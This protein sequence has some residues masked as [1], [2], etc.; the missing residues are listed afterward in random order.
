MRIGS[1]KRGVH[2]HVSNRPSDHVSAITISLRVDLRI[3]P[4]SPHT[5]GAPHQPRESTAALSVIAGQFPDRRPLDTRWTQPLRRTCSVRGN[6]LDV[7]PTLPYTS[8]GIWSCARKGMGVQLPPRAPR[9]C[10]SYLTLGEA[11]AAV[12]FRRTHWCSRSAHGH[13]SKPRP[14][15]LGDTVRRKSVTPRPQWLGRH[16]WIRALLAPDAVDLAG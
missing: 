3:T 11:R 16:W 1:P 12:R 6:Q 13:S 9:E 2:P 10:G 14:F 5:A 15:L 7:T 8:A 4:G